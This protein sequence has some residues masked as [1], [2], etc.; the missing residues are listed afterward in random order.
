MELYVFQFVLFLMLFLRTT[1]LIAM[2]PVFGHVA[3]P[4][5]VKV[6]LG[7]F[8]AFVLYPVLAARTPHLDL[9]LAPLVIMGVQEV[10]TGLFIGFAMGLIFSG[11]RAAGEL[12]GFE[13]GLSIA[14]AFDPETG[15]NN[16]IGAFLYLVAMLVFLLV[17]GHHVVLQA[18][19]LSY[20]AVPLNG[21]V[22]GGAAVDRLVRLTGLVF[23][24]AVQCA[25]PVIV[26]SFLVNVAL[27]I[28][29]RVAPAVN[30]F[31]VSFPV[32]IAV[33]MLVLMTS[34]P[35]LVFAFK[36]LLGGFQEQV[37]QFVRV[38]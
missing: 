4:V 7:A 21:L 32:K 11:V 30:V 10:L 37:L 27:A 26:A 28:L 23:I 29:A 14:T 13:L 8:M 35:F 16:V 19:V 2:A 22:F 6:G 15:P 24:V 9:Q 34:A 25:A 38:L 18:L 31:I 36:K 5:Q 17:N 12:I 20:D 3:V 1:S 33:G